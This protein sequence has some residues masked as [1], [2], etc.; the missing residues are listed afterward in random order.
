MSA[1]LY[2]DDD[3]L[4]LSPEHAAAHAIL[5]QGGFTTA[6]IEPERMLRSGGVQAER[7]AEWLKSR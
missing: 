6:E 3:G 2:T 5:V 7:A 4:F 1:D